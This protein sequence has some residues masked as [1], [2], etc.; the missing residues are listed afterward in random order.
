MLAAPNLHKDLNVLQSVTFT[1]DATE[2]TS[3]LVGFVLPA[4]VVI[5]PAAC[6]VLIER[7]FNGTSPTLAI[8]TQPSG[9]T[10]TNNSLFQTG[11]I[12][13]GTPGFYAASAAHVTAG[14]LNAMLTQ[15]LA[16]VVTQSNTDST[17]GLARITIAYSSLVQGVHW[18]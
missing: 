14:G 5:V 4:N 7:A 9:G 12:T 11:D 10:L 13:V 16:V 17:A 1:Y 6:Q 18:E 3:G 8:G 15:D 2:N